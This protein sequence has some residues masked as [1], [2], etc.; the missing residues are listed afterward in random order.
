MQRMALVI[1][2]GSGVDDA[3]AQ[4]LAADGHRVAVTFG[5]TRLPEVFR[6]GGDLTQSGVESAFDQAEAALG[7]VEILVANPGM[8]RTPPA[9][10][11]NTT[12]FTYGVRIGLEA[13][14]V[15]AGRARAAM[16][17]SQ[18]GRMIFLASPSAMVDEIGPARFG[19]FSL[20]AGLIG[21]A[22]SLTGELAEHNIAV[23]V[24]APG[25]IEDD[26]QIQLKPGTSK[27]PMWHIPAL[28]VGRLTEVAAVVSF[29]ASD[30]AAYVNGTTLRVDGGL[31]V[32]PGV[33]S[34]L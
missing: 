34:R 10:E 28:R 30:G 33:A 23:N 8:P 24:V 18:W 3:V 20:N 26:E 15:A 29:L 22:E 13:A 1:G 6:V 31:G 27:N 32:R 9:P 17:R 11:F 12:D 21:L 2:T 14:F 5:E 25:L 7:P 4:A 16:Q 19:A